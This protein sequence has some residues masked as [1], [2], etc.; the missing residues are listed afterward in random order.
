MRSPLLISILLAAA[1]LHAGSAC[2][3]Q[4]VVA[5]TN[6][7]EVMAQPRIHFVLWGA[8]WLTPAGASGADQTV[9]SFSRVP[10]LYFS[11]LAQYGVNTPQLSGMTVATAYEPPYY[12]TQDAVALMLG[13]LT[14]AG[15]LL[16][17]PR[18]VYYIVLLPPGLTSPFRG[19]H[20]YFQDFD[21]SV[22]W[23]AYVMP[24]GDATLSAIFHELVEGV[25]DPEGRGV[26]TVTP[27]KS[28]LYWSE[29][30]DACEAACDH[31][32]ISGVPVP[33]YWSQL[34]GAC[35]APGGDKKRTQPLPVK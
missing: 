12:I 8:Y 33:A 29:I 28:P 21:G 19:F 16:P 26:Q 22:V 24:N 10:A 3:P 30:A 1:S 25:T 18:S 15:V 6:R 5:V 23:F 27:V 4:P 14:R 31:A 20:S 7:G 32:S 13:S 34:D 2:H 35:I 17:S 9:R 11:G